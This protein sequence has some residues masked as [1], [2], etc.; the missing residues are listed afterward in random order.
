MAHNQHELLVQELEREIL[1]YL[2]RNPVAAE[3]RD[4]I[5]QFWIMRERF[6][7]GLSALDDALASLVRRGELERVDLPD[8]EA[9]YRAA[10][11]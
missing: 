1:D 7:R 6:A 4:A 9:I 10:R 2:A 3:H 5:F 11:R 8:G